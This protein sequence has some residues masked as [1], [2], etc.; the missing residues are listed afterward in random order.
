MRTGREPLQ[1]TTE[2]STFHSCPTPA[3]RWWKRPLD[4]IAGVV[5]LLLLLVPLAVLV[6]LVRLDSPGSGIYR[7]ERVGRAGRP[8]RIWKLRTMTTRCDQSVHRASAANWFQGRDH[9]GRFKS[10]DDP[11]ITAF[12]RWLRKTNLDELPQLVNVLRGQMSLVGPRPA[13]PYELEHYQPWY[14]ERHQ[15]RPGMTGL[16]Q[17]SRRECLSAAEMM[18]LDCRYVREASLWLDLKILAATGP[19]LVQAVREAR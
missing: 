17:V 14:H 11:R 4:L 13:I 9:D 16:W 10:L 18:E 19:A 7:Q 12:G 15:V 1:P 2:S 6:L 3:H 8:F 5:L